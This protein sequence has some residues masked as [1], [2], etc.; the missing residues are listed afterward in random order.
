MNG[1]TE[2]FMFPNVHEIVNSLSHWC[3]FHSV[4]KT[5]TN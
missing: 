3:S 2:I 1:F 5:A 4:A